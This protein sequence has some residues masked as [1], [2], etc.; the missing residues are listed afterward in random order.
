MNALHRIL[1]TS[2]ARGLLAIALT[3][4]TCCFTSAVSAG[5]TVGP[6]IDG[7][8]TDL[9]NYAAQLEASGDGCGLNIVD[10]PDANNNPTPE[11]IYNDAKFIPCPQ[12][13][14]LLGTHWVNGVEIFNSYFAY[15]HGSTTLFLGIHAEGFI[16]DVDGNGNP[17]NSGGG[18]CN[19]NDNIEDTI[20]ISGN[21][22]YSW[23]FDLDCNGSTDGT[24]KVQDNTVTGTG[25]LAGATGI[26]AFRQN[27]GS[28]ATGHDLEVQVN[29]P[30][31][32][33]PAFNF[34]RVEANA[35]DGLSED[36]VDGAPC[37]ADS[38]INVLK[39]ANPLTVCPNGTTRFTITV[40]NTGDTPL[41]VV[42]VDQ[43][44]ASLTYA[45][46]LSGTC[47]V[48]APQ[49]SGSTLTFPAFNVAAGASC[50]IAFDVTASP[51]CFGPVTNRVDVT[52]TFTSGCIT[53]NN[54]AQ[55]VTDFAEATVTCKAPPCVQVDITCPATACEGKSYEVSATVKNCSLE[56]EDITLTI[57]GTPFTIP[58]VAAGASATRSR[59][60]TMGTCTPQGEAHTATATA[61][62]SCNITTPPVSDNCTTLCAPNPCVEFT[63][64]CPGQACAGAPINLVGTARNCSSAPETITMTIDGTQYV[65]NDVPAGQS[66]SHTKTL[67]MPQCTPGQPIAYNASATATN[68]C[69]TSQPVNRNC[70]VN[71]LAGPCVDLVANPNTPACAGSQVALSG[72][73]TNCGT[74]TESI[75]IRYN[76]NVIATCPSV[77]PGGTCTYNT[78]VTMPACTSGNVP[79]NI[80]ASATAD[81]GSVEDTATHN[82]P[83]QTPQIDVEKVATES[84]VANLGTIHYTITL[85][86]PSATVALENIVV[87]DHLCSYA[88]YANN[89]SPA[90]FSA[91]AVGANGNVVWHVDNLAPGAQVVFTFQVTVDVAFGGGTCPT[92]VQCPNIVDA[93]GYCL[94]S[95]GTSSARDED[96]ITTPITCAGE[97]CPRT[98]GFWTQQCAQKGNGST[99]FT[100]TQVTNIAS[101]I[102]D[103]SSFFN[104]SNDFDSFCITV[105][106]PT[107]NQRVQA[108]RQFATLLANF[109][110]DQLNLQPSQGG[111]IF[112]PGDTPVHCNGLH[113]TTISQLIDE[114]DAL[115]TQL[116]GQDLSSGSVKSQY[117]SII[118]CI[119]AINNGVSIPTRIDCAEGTSGS[120]STG[121]GVGTP[122][123][124]NGSAV[125][126][127]RP[128]PNP[129]SGTTTFAYNIAGANGAH[130][131][132][133]VF[134]VAGR[135]IKKL[136]SGIQ[137][138]GIH[139]ATWDGRNDQGAQ[140]QR[141]VYFVRT[142]I[143]GRK[144]ATN[145]ILY[146]TEAR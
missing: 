125:E 63:F 75:T 28:G 44:P 38:K 49:V 108:K 86:N 18:S 57:D 144:E 124:A 24:I 1:R 87:T 42:A 97:A 141:G 8:P 84:S 17:D 127:Y 64:E 111:E 25:T 135:Q 76:G 9:I 118:S 10:K 62:N 89:A 113:S 68:S 32:L 35:F 79:F 102:D 67:N 20:G 61:T 6:V 71:C 4:A 54:G 81:C 101:C 37:I 7:N 130:A 117:G 52:G 112:L 146:L 80:V 47:N 137:T 39:D 16:G 26:I 134:D 29:L 93:V 140:V 70:S 30:A 5:G 99:K 21:E 139:T 59:T 126:L 83:C 31:P 66:V 138:A 2:S 116:E 96:Q 98:P 106:P 107:M 11:T 121:M 95:G 3:V 120:R 43:L 94:G 45:G 91:P 88:K 65:S 53:E 78:T 100:K 77:A 110:T 122:G 23:S 19:P 103:R 22:L 104:W 132:I 72:T 69:G 105:N 55:I 128:S 145:R 131:E 119:D 56:A 33:P 60:F 36:R 48:G 114:V 129:F 85:R 15:A 115:L 46:N 92:T 41:S 133:T 12:P 136:V 58:G 51:Q 40:Q 73:A 82:V 14:P 142:V 13:Q 109:C 74:G 34:L 123:E 27:A 143:A 50:T 90:P